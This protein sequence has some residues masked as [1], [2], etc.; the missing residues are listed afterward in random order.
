MRW[1]WLLLIA[2]CVQSTA[3]IA[4]TPVGGASPV[5]PQVAGMVNGGRFDLKLNPTTFDAGSG[6]TLAI[7]GTVSGTMT[8]G[9]S[10]VLT[11]DKPLPTGA[12]KRF[13][14]KFSAGIT[15][16]EIEADRITAVTDAMGKRFTWKLTETP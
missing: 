2:G 16:L 10:I 11:F 7:P 1:G 13:G 3:P 15:R 12:A 9:G 8:G 14:L 4:P 6:A 5:F